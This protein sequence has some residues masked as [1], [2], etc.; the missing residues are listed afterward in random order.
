MR[1]VVLTK[2]FTA[3]IQ[4]SRVASSLK[5]NQ[6]SLADREELANYGDHIDWDRTSENVTLVSSKSLRLSVN[7]VFKPYVDDYNAHQKRKDRKINDY[8]TK[9]L[10]NRNLTPVQE[11]VV[12]FGDK[13]TIFSADS[14]Q[15]HEKFKELYSQYLQGF[16]ERNRNLRVASAVIHFDEKGGPHMHMITIPV[17]HYSRGMKARANFDRAMGWNEHRKDFDDFR[18]FSRWKA[19]AF[20][21]WADNERDELVNTAKSMG[22]AIER[23]K[24]AVPHTHLEPQE[25]RDLQAKLDTIKQN[26]STEN[27]NLS[28]IQK[29]KNAL[30]LEVSQLK[31][32]KDVYTQ[33]IH[34]LQSQAE[35]EKK[36]VY[37]LN[38][39]VTALKQQKDEASKNVEQLQA[40]VQQL[41]KQ[42]HEAQEA[43]NRAYADR[44]AKYL[45]TSTAWGEYRDQMRQLKEDRWN[46]WNDPASCDLFKQRCRE[47]RETN[48]ALRAWRGGGV[49]AHTVHFILKLKQL[50]KERQLQELKDEQ[51]RAMQDLQQ[52]SEALAQQR[53]DLLQK[54]KDANK[55]IADA[56]DL[57]NEVNESLK[58]VK[59]DV[60]DAQKYVNFA[61]QVKEKIE[62]GKVK[63]N[64]ALLALNRKKPQQRVDENELNKKQEQLSVD[65][66]G[67]DDGRGQQL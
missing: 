13:H 5:H 11:F 55:A 51:A 19:Q 52:R 38:Q 63:P 48:R 41:Q 7:E 36:N 43:V 15:N 25:Y 23:K 44:K 56:K 64:D 16:K 30:S 21:D 49:I 42:K 12:Q 29:N 4:K 61:Q 32:K 8:Y 26:V 57:R 62:Q 9:C 40:L 34:S 47:L 27:E 54:S 45:E 37:T 2:A 3:S 59:E 28:T 17:G 65:L 46:L 1:V 20:A 33:D 14:V 39:D 53:K 60:H 50:S 18:Q 31:Q 35:E 6:R 66:A 24:Q 58:Q 67:L 22:Y 10:S